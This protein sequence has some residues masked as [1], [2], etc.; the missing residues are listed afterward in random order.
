MTGFRYQVSGGIHKEVHQRE[1]SRKLCLGEVCGLRPS[2]LLVLGGLA[3]AALVALHRRRRTHHGPRP[4][5]NVLRG[6]KRLGLARRHGNPFR[7]VQSVAALYARLAAVNDHPCRARRVLAEVCRNRTDRSTK[8]RPTGFEVLGE[9]QP[10]CTS[11]M[12]LGD[13]Q[14]HRQLPGGISDSAATILPQLRADFTASAGQLPCGKGRSAPPQRIAV[15]S[16]RM[17]ATQAP[18]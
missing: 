6:A 1:S 3:L 18:S 15:V 9:H 5:L 8:G 13:L 10:A 14:P 12:S 7:E 11:V 17:L 4:A 2:R 16:A